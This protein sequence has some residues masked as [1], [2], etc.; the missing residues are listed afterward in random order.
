VFFPGERRYFSW[1]LFLAL[2]LSAAT[3]LVA[4]RGQVYIVSNRF[5]LSQNSGATLIKR[6]LAVPGDRIEFRGGEI[7]V[8]GKKSSYT[9]VGDVDR[10]L[11]LAE[12][13]YFVV[14]DNSSYS[15]DSRSFGPVSGGD[16]QGIVIF[17]F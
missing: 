13:Q 9:D 7:F 2:N 1:F 5:V 17:H 15:T 6:M 14:G 4:L 11:V 3:R 16:L 12:N 8:N 10:T